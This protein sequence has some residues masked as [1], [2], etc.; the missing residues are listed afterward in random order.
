MKLVVVNLQLLFG[1]KK[2]RKKDS[3]TITKCLHYYEVQYNQPKT[4]HVPN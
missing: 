3:N 4:G 2:S 1:K